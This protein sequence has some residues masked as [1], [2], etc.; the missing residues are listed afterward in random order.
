MIDDD[1]TDFIES[2]LDARRK[3]RLGRLPLEDGFKGNKTLNE[4]IDRPTA[5]TLYKM[6]SDGVVSGIEG[7][8]GAGKESL[9][10][11]GTLSTGG[12]AAMKVY[13]VSTSNFKRR[14]FYMHGD[15]RFS[16]FRNKTRDI[17]Y[18]W[19]QKEFR[20]LRQAWG[21]GMRVPRPL[22]VSRNVLAM[23]F[24]GEEGRPAP[25]LL[26]SDVDEDDYAQAVDILKVLYNK[27][28]LIH[29]DYSEYNIFKTRQGL[30]PFDLGSAV[31]RRHPSAGLLLRRDINNINRFFAKRQIPVRDVLEIEGGMT[32][33]I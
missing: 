24:I 4:V 23:E 6:I 8:V 15:P 13:L 30:V 19:A 11:R 16:R 10:F 29:G 20:N 31:D 21:V 33:D 1:N 26:Y 5:M 12:Y 32:H 2:K 14:T 18:M 27:A 22:A 7:A 3:A 17:V 9:L 25:T 28:G